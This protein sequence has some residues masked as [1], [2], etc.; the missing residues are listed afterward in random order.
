MNRSDTPAVRQWYKKA[1]MLA[2][3][4][5]VLMEAPVTPPM[6][7]PEGI[8]QEPAYGPN[9]NWPEGLAPVWEPER[10][11]KR[12][13]KRHR[14]ERSPSPPPRPEVKRKRPA[15]RSPTPLMPDEAYPIWDECDP[16]SVSA[17]RPIPAHPRT[18]R[19][20]QASPLNTW[21]RSMREGTR[22]PRAHLLRA[23]KRTSGQLKKQPGKNPQWARAQ[24]PFRLRAMQVSQKGK[25]KKR[26]SRSWAGPIPKGASPNPGS[27]TKKKKR[28]GKRLT[29][30]Q[31][32]LTAKGIQRAA[33]RA[34]LQ[35]G[36][37]AEQATAP[38]EVAPPVMVP[39]PPALA[40]E[41]LGVKEE[42]G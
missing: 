39:P 25:G 40:Y 42:R 23:Q 28:R 17:A 22:L 8:W 20:G 6:F 15:S 14:S 16:S 10:S 3:E 13:K 1:E 34:H 33:D 35:P 41:E 19:V 37:A 7:K 30:E 29:A 27:S 32:M 31:R 5:R 18:I 26:P 36:Q 4:G 24:H 38:P 2:E 11:S 21:Q 12:R 9:T